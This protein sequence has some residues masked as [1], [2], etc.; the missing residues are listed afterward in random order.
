MKIR[1]FI[2]PMLL[3]ATIGTAQTANDTI[4]RM[5]LVESTYNPI[6]AGAVKRNF[7]PEEVR[8]SMNKEAAVYTDGNVSPIR[9][10]SH[11]Q[12]AQ[13]MPI[14]SSKGTRGYA[15]IGYGNYNNLS[16][17][18]AYKL[19]LKGSNELSFKGHVNG[20]N[21]KYKQ[22]DNTKWSSHLYDMG[23]STNYRVSLGEASLEAGIDATHTDY[24]YLSNEKE[25]V[26]KSNLL[27]A[28][29]GIKGSASEH[30]YYRVNASYTYY[31]RATHF[32]QKVLHSEN[33]IH[34]N[35]SLSRDLYSWG[36]ATIDVHS[37]I[38]TYHG[39]NA[40]T[41]YF[42]LG[43][44]PH[45]DYRLGDFHFTSGLNMDFL[46]GKH[47]IHPMQISPECSI[48]YIPESRFSALLT[49]D[50]GRDIHTFGNLYAR[51]PYWATEGQLRPT[52]TLLNARLEGGIRIIDGLHLHLGGGYKILSD[53]L[54]ETVMDSIG[55][56]YT[57]IINHNAQMATVDGAINYTHKDLVSLSAKGT[58]NYWTLQGD[59]ALLARAPQLMVDLDTRVRI[60]PN[61]HAYTNLKLVMFSSK[62]EDAIIDWGIGAQYNLN[63]RFTIFLDGHNFLNHRHQYFTGYPSQGFN[64]LAGAIVKF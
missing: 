54:F 20:W 9:I 11:A 35:A 49:L 37:D 55:T 18:A 59:Q 46:G 53:A 51:S 44:T 19:N 33:H 57:G 40:Y 16:A 23:L 10:N 30:Y 50:G 63:K 32:T 58:Y 45:W 43:I 56:T 3:S 28:N 34:A 27:A 8:P 29:M 25:D 15:H 64:V 38:L 41:D 48:S 4:N 21:G 39:T 1:I 60:M 7:I 13:A 42:S 6:I 61:L 2:L 12:P 26:Q 31:D 17:Q 62:N 52:Y 47:T 5:V 14:T 24:N 36:M 22:T